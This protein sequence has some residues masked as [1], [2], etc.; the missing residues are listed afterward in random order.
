MLSAKNKKMSALEEIN[1]RLQGYDNNPHRMTWKESLA[2]LGTQ[3]TNR[4][5]VILKE[6]LEGWVGVW[7]NE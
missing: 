4:G 7:E 6:G 1:N 3:K 2:L 5:K